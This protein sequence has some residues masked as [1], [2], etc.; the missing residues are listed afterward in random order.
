MTDGDIDVVLL[1]VDRGDGEERG[2]RPALNDLEVVDQAP[3]DVLGR[4]EVRFDPPAQLGQPH[5]LRIRQRGLVLP[6]QR[7]RLFPSAA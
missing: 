2:D 1:V 6:L 4:A 5:D 3:F 7:D